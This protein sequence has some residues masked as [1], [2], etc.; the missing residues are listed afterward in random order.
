MQLLPHIPIFTDQLRHLLLQAIILLHQQLVHS[1]QFSIHSLKPRGFFSLFLTAPIKPNKTQFL[2]KLIFFRR[3]YQTFWS[4]I[5]NEFKPSSKISKPAVLEP[6]FDLLRLDVGENGALPDQL[7]PAHGAGLGTLSIDS[8][9]SFNLLSS[10][11][12]ILAVIK[13]LV[14]ATSTTTLSVLSH[15]HRHY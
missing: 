14:Y 11:A 13:V 4:R 2:Q 6:D 12:D 8:L 7:L 10:V 9:K 15:G 5:K 3:K 1:W